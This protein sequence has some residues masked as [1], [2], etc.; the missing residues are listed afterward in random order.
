MKGKNGPEESLTDVDSG[1][2][3]TL[4]LVRLYWGKD[5]VD[6]AKRLVVESHFPSATES[7]SVSQ[8]HVVWQHS[9]VADLS[10]EKL[11]AFVD[12][13]SLHGLQ[14]SE[15]NLSL[16]LLKRVRKIAEQ[17]FVGGSFLTP[18]TLRYDALDDSRY[19]FDKCCIFLSFPYFDIHTPRPTKGFKKGDIRH[20]MRTLLQSRY[21]LNST[22]ERDKMQC[23]RVLKGVASE[24]YLQRVKS[25]IGHGAAQVTEDLIYVPQLWS[26]ITGVDH[27]I[28]TGPVSD[29]MLQGPSIKFVDDA[30][31][32]GLRKCSLVRIAFINR[33]K[34]ETLTYPIEQ[35]SCWFGLLNKHQQIRGIL[36]KDHQENGAA[37]KEYDPHDYKLH[38][39]GHV[40]DGRIWPSVQQKTENEVLDLWMRTPK[41]DL[42]KFSKMDG[43]PDSPSG[44]QTD[45]D[46]YWEGTE[47][48]ETEPEVLYT[49]LDTVPI[50]SPFLEWQ[51]LDEFG[52]PD[53]SPLSHKLDRSLNAIYGSLPI[54]CSTDTVEISDF[55][56]ARHGVSGKLGK[57]TRA[58]L[59][60]GGKT[61]IDVNTLLMTK[62]L[63]VNLSQQAL[64]QE[65]FQELQKLFGR[66][67]PQKHDINS[68]PIQSYWGMVFE[69]LVSACGVPRSWKHD[70]NGTPSKI[71]CL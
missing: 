63:E 53:P 55:G 11:E 38:I 65:L 4:R 9:V 57:S 58:K 16:R 32:G 15:I 29:R 19:G 5:D 26:V 8:N 69:I 28:T 46:P 3:T 60:V 52:E 54:I 67:I 61:S 10:L 34:P 36:K 45:D 44:D 64:K 17:E 56:S 12:K 22:A 31:A 50:V 39:K 20:P 47:Q 37:D 14:K 25:L 13:S 40:I 7:K 24:G 62:T 33:G 71:T 35:C 68:K 49:H 27:L 30:V 2:Q 41:R 1:V 21:R 18:L 59:R 66:F 23:I 70:A 43:D 51:I 48:F 6:G 42:P